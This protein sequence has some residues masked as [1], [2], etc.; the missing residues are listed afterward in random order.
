[1]YLYTSHSITTACNT[2]KNNEIF[3]STKFSFSFFKLWR[4]LPPTHVI[5]HNS[6]ILIVSPPITNNSPVPDFIDRNAKCLKT[7]QTTVAMLLKHKWNINRC[8]V[9][10]KHNNFVTL[11]K[12]Y[13]VPLEFHSTCCCCHHHHRKPHGHLQTMSLPIIKHANESAVRHHGRQCGRNTVPGLYRLDTFHPA[14]QRA[15]SDIP[16]ATSNIAY[17]SPL[18]HNQNPGWLKGSGRVVI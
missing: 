14:H 13:K 11:F 17:W 10:Q 6:L 4:L 2:I 3:F 9:K 12:H 7:T 1:M 5:Q 18:L 15:I 16:V 8:H